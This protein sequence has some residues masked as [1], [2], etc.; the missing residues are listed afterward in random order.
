[1]RAA[2]QAHAQARVS[3][4]EECAE[5]ALISASR[6]HEAQRAAACL[7][8]ELQEMESATRSQQEA[9]IANAKADAAESI[10]NA[11]LLKVMAF[12]ETAERVTWINSIVAYE[13]LPPAIVVFATNYPYGRL[14]GDKLPRRPSCPRKTTPTIVLFAKN[15]P[16]IV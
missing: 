16:T 14:V 3:Y 13:E 9:E 11:N 10:A 5:A 15:Y 1:M 12:E 7:V 6:A 4:T 8:S 2:V